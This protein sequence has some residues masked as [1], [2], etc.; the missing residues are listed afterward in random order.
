VATGI[1]R[2]NGFLMS[3]ATALLMSF[4]RKPERGAQ[5]LVWLATAPEQSLAS[6]AYYVDM[7][8]HAPTAEAQDAAAAQR[9]W[10]VSEAQ[11]KRSA[12]ETPAG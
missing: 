4:A 6:G 8:R 9:L 1:N 5:T 11:C 3:V 2:N 7:E 10:E 12:P